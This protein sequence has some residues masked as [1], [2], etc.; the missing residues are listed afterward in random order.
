MRKIDPN[1]YTPVTQ[2]TMNRCSKCLR[3]TGVYED[4]HPY[5]WTCVHCGNQ[6]YAQHDGEF[7]Y[8]EKEL[9][10]KPRSKELEFYHRI[11]GK[12][13]AELLG[14]YFDEANKILES[15]EES[16]ELMQVGDDESEII[17]DFTED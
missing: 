10:T 14:K 12:E 4:Q 5:F 11:Y 2:G 6:N 15:F 17:A 1:N 8:P 3:K 13:K 9:S 16:F 7:D